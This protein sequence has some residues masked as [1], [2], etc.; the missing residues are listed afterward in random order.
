MAELERAS[1]LPVADQDQASQIAWLRETLARHEQAL[2]RYAVRITG[3]AELGRDVVQDTFLKLA[4]VDRAQLDGHL[5]EWLYTVARRRAIDVRRKE[6]R[7]ESLTVEAAAACMCQEPDPAL[8]FERRDEVARVHEMLAHLGEREQEAVR[9]KF[10]H[11][12]TYREIAGVLG[13]TPNHVGVI[14][15][16]A[17]N[18]VRRQL[19]AN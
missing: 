2:V 4:L 10:E 5:V 12:L 19:S 16:T 1:P 3:D 18:T 8:A 6:Q 15:H 13:I 7:M 17:L 14:L 11:G 9:L